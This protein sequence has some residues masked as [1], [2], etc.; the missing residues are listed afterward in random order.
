MLNFTIPDQVR[1][2]PMNVFN[3]TLGNEGFVRSNI[4]QTLRKRSQIGHVIRAR[5]VGN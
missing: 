1:F 3:D 2:G 5:F 4:Q